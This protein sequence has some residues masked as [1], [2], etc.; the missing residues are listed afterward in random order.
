MPKSTSRPFSKQQ[1]STL[2]NLVVA[3]IEHI[4]ATSRKDRHESY[5]LAKDVYDVQMEQYIEERNERLYNEA[6]RHPQTYVVKGSRGS[7]VRLDNEK[8]NEWYTAKYGPAPTLPDDPDKTMVDVRFASFSDRYGYDGG[9]KVRVSRDMESRVQALSY[10]IDQAVL[11]GQ[12]DGIV[13]AIN[14]L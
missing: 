2:H 13:E 8:L 4:L 3:K 11:S 6:R 14:A 5:K 1:M 10:I 7:P 9:A 12:A